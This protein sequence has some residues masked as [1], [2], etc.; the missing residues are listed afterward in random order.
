MTPTRC[1]C[2]RTQGLRLVAQTLEDDRV[3]DAVASTLLLTSQIM[4]VLCTG[5][6]QGEGRE[7]GFADLGT[8]HRSLRR[9]LIF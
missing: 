1:V 7:G 9:S 3:S 6:P 2:Q 5:M 4:E 8:E